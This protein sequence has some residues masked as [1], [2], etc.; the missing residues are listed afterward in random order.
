[1]SLYD[2]TGFEWFRAANKGR[3]M[4]EQKEQKTIAELDAA[5]QKAK[6]VLVEMEAKAD[7]QRTL[8][9]E[10]AGEMFAILQR[11]IGG[12]AKPTRKRGAK[13]T[14]AQIEQAAETIKGVLSKKD[15]KKARDIAAQ[16]KLDKRLVALALKSLLE[17]KKIKKEGDKSATV[18]ML[19]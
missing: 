18:Y 17:N 5:Y 2:V 4:S 9:A 16:T 10:L 12:E 19:V 14:E 3:T 15:A 1:M 13:I 7:A 6:A 11:D 8:V